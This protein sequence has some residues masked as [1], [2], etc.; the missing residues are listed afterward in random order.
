MENPVI[1]IKIVKY[2][3]D[4]KFRVALES[5]ESLREDESKLVPMFIKDSQALSSLEDLQ[6]FWI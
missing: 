2:S 5:G 1:R 6:R 3:C 4:Q